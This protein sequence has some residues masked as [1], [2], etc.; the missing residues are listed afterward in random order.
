MT[1]FLRSLASDET[2]VAGVEYAF[3]I[4]VIALTLIGDMVNIGNEVAEMYGDT[5]VKYLAANH[6]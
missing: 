2:G 5:H 6:R 3:L 4:A 1:S